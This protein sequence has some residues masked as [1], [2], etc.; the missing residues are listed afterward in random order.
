MNGWLTQLV[1]GLNTMAN[2]CGRVLLA[3]IAW[4]PGWL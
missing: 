3:P 1:D 4:L 2:A